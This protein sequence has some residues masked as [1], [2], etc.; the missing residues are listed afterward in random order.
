MDMTNVIAA[1]MAGQLDDGLESIQQAIRER[2]RS[3]GDVLRL[4]I[5]PGT[6][7]RLKNLSPKYLNGLEGTVSTRK[8]KGKRIP[9][10]LDEG[11]HRFGK[12]LNPPSQCLEVIE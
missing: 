7:V 1:I 11:V 10:D 4:T 5:K 2:N 12:T 8:R 3:R 6:R 9:V